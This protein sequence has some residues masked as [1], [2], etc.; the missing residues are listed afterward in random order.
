M[1][2]YH[3]AA[4]VREPPQINYL[5]SDMQDRFGCSEVGGVGGG[6]RQ[7]RSSAYGI[8]SLDCDA[9]H[10]PSKLNTGVC[11][12]WVPI[13]RRPVC[14]VDEGVQERCYFLMPRVRTVHSLP[15][16]AAPRSTTG[17]APLLRGCGWPCGVRCRGP[18]EPH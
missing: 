10:T 14:L 11:G 3:S 9:K 2:T 15:S 18:R 5:V 1:M 6:S 17:R 7:S 8:P 12:V 4:A 16:L 13:N